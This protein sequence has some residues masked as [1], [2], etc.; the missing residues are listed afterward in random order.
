MTALI[1]D[2]A[3]WSLAS[4]LWIVFVSFAVLSTIDR[5]HRDDR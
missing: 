4:V 3:V 2:L 1:Y 5:F